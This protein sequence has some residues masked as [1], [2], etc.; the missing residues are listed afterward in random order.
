MT[1]GITATC[2]VSSDP[3]GQSLSK[4]LTQIAAPDLELLWLVLH[5]RCL[6]PQ[7]IQID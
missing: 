5:L 6:A 4:R 2:L 1:F 3:L 7:D